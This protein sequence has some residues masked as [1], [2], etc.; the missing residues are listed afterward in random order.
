MKNLDGI[1]IESLVGG[2]D[3][4]ISYATIGAT[5][6]LVVGPIGIGLG[7]AIGAIAD[8]VLGAKAKK[9][10]RKKMRRA[11]MAAL[12]KRYHTQIFSSS[13]ERLGG[14]MMHLVELR[15]KP[16]T[17]KFDE[18]LKKMT[19]KEI[20]YTGDCSINLLSPAK[21]GEKRSVIA[22]I[23]SGRGGAEFA[24]MTAYAPGLDASLPKVWYKACKDLHL[25]ALKAWAEEK[26]LDIIEERERRQASAESKRKTA[27]R[28]MVNGGL[29]LVMLGYSIRRKRKLKGE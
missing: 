13:L 12:L 18:L 1:G 19:Y 11:F 25:A 6:G 10:A 16:G 29:I 22:V 2:G 21:P 24:K 27:T 3:A 8:L 26:K 15:V 28:F 4:P 14:A 9:K 23:T 20:G 7:M 17:Q 5:I